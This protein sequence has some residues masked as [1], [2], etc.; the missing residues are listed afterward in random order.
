MPQTKK[1]SLIEMY[2]AVLRTI[3][4]GTAAPTRIMY[5]TNLSWKPLTKILKSLERQ[6]LIL[7]KST[8][9]KFIYDITEKGKL[10]LRQFDT[11][12]E[13]MKTD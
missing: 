4:K 2:V 13:T 9:G 8:D 3:K 7:K 6:R 1:R 5:K 11:L 12:K 10:A